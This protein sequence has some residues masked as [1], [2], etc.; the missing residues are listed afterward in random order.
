MTISNT[1]LAGYIDLGYGLTCHCRGCGRSFEVDLQKLLDRVG[2]DFVMVG[3]NVRL[4][5]KCKECGGTDFHPT[6]TVNP[7]DIQGRT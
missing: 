1:N 7:A 6:V 2:P 5:I 3:K 4:P